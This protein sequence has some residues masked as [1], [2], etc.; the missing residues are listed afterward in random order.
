M[1]PQ[2]IDPLHG[3][4]RVGI[5]VMRYGI[6]S[7]LL[8]K[9]WCRFMAYGN[10]PGLRPSAPTLAPNSIGHVYF[11]DIESIA[12]HYSAE[13]LAHRL[14]LDHAKLFLDE[15][16]LVIIFP[17]GK[18]G[19]GVPVIGGA[20]IEKTAGGANQWI[21]DSNVSFSTEQLIYYVLSSTFLPRDSHGEEP[22]PEQANKMARWELESPRLNDE[23][24]WREVLFQFKDSSRSEGLLPQGEE[25]LDEFLSNP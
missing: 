14:T 13:A 18:E 24:Y 21:T 8:L 2:A 23:N 19:A 9:D 15:G 1:S 11:T 3:G 6:W 20:P 5:R 12:G 22:S 7:E 17:L 10:R 25:D 16:A 4:S